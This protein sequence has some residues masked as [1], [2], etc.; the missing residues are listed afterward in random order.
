M[1]WALPY[2]IEKIVLTDLSQAVH[3]C[4]R[5]L[6]F[7]KGRVLVQTS[8]GGAYNL[9][10]ILDSA[11]LF[12]KEFQRAGVP[13]ERY[14][15]KIMATGPGVVAANILSRAS[16]PILGTGVFTVAQAVA[17][18]QAHC[19]FI[20]PY[21]NSIADLQSVSLQFESPNGYQQSWSERPIRD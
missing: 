20:S 4:K 1:S 21:Y 11:R 9:Q 17:C 12:V 2:A 19:L 15:I 10:E 5:N 18:F 7:I 8:P 13:R 3:F 16:I 14:C 6:P